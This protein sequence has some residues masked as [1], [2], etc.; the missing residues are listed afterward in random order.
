MVAPVGSGGAGGAERKFGSHQVELFEAAVDG[1]QRDPET[2][3]DLIG[4]HAVVAA[5]PNEFELVLLR[6]ETSGG[7]GGTRGESGQDNVL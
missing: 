2:F 4:S 1:R 7:Q 3:G 6:S 5:E